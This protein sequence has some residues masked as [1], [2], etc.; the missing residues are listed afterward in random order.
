MFLGFDKKTLDWFL[1]SDMALNN[2]DTVAF[3][4]SAIRM[5]IGFHSNHRAV[6]AI[7]HTIRLL[8]FENVIEFAFLDGFAQESEHI[9]GVPS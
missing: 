6:F 9:T 1:L 7:A 4:D 5:T 3:G 8:H 2:G